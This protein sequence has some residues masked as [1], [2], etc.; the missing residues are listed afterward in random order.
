M[1]LLKEDFGYGQIAPGGIGDY[2][3]AIIEGADTSFNPQKH[4]EQYNAQR[5]QVA[6]LAM[7][8]GTNQTLFILD[9]MDKDNMVAAPMSWYSGWSYKSLDRGLVVEFGAAYCADGMNALDWAIASL[10]V[11]I[12]TIG[13][14]GFAGDYGGDWA[15]GIKYAAE[16]NGITV[17]WEYLP[18]T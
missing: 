15:Q 13:I 17:A 6:A 2:S 14:M 8:L 4:L 12:K 16:R 10:P 11:D 9:E 3:V 5:D 7:S 1:K 18:P